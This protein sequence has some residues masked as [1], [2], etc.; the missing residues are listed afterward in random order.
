MVV[1]AGIGGDPG[2]YNVEKIPWITQN[3]WIGSTLKAYSNYT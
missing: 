3:T 2:S 1:E